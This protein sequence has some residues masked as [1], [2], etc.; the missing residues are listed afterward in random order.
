MT[1]FVTRVYR[2]DKLKALKKMIAD[3]TPTDAMVEAGRMYILDNLGIGLTSEFVKEL[4]TAM[5]KAQ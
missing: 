5:K 4:Y 1:S 2:T 3:Q